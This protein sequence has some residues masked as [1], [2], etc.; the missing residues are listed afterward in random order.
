MASWNGNQ[1]KFQGKRVGSSLV[2]ILF[3]N[4]GMQ[5]LACTTQNPIMFC[6]LRKL[7]NKV[8]PSPEQK[9]VPDN[10]RS[11]GLKLIRG[12][13]GVFHQDTFIVEDL[14]SRCLYPKIPE[15]KDQIVNNW[16][17][18]ALKIKEGLTCNGFLFI[19]EDKK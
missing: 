16:F 15:S 14:Y 1:Q 17:K 3:D 19:A 10:L 9:L 8:Y 2:K 6:F 12:R 11:L 18:N 5:K 4:S 7:F 13:R